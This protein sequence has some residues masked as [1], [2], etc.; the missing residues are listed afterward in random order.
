LALPSTL[1]VQVGAKADPVA[2]PPSAQPVAMGA[3]GA[4]SDGGGSG[5]SGGGAADPAVS[6]LEARLQN[7]RRN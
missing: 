4:P 7:L 6:D 1:L 3:D 5:G 2:A